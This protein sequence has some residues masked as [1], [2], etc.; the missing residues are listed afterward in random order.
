[1]AAATAPDS[2]VK[3]L[4]NWI[5]SPSSSIPELERRDARLV[6]SLAFVL[7]IS[8]SLR[9]LFESTLDIV[10]VGSFIAMIISYTLSRTTY[11]KLAAGII[12]A[13]LIIPSLSNL[14]AIPDSSNLADWVSGRAVW[15]A[16]P[17]V[18]G[19]IF[20]SWRGILVI[21]IGLFATIA[22]MPNFND[23][24]IFN[25]MIGSMA[26]IGI[27]TAL[28]VLAQ[29]HR[30]FVEEDRRAELI[31]ANKAL[32][33]ARNNLEKR[34]DER[35][36]ELNVALQAAQH[37]DQVK[38]AFLASMSHELRTP[39]NSVINFTKFVVKGVM[40]PVTERQ[41]DTL[42]KVIASGQHLLSLINDVLD[43]SKIESGSLNLF[44]EDDVNPNEI[45]QTIID[46][47]D[48]LLIDKEIEL[49][50]DIQTELPMMLADRKRITQILLNVVSNA[51]KFTEEGFVKV[52]A[53]LENNTL[54]VTVQDTGPGIA[55]EDK[56]AVF[57]SFKQTDTGLR[58]GEGTGLGMPIS[59]NLAE[60]HGGKLWFESEVGQGTTFYVE[61]PVKSDVLKAMM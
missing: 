34:V 11:R 61:L 17:M 35:T 38:S 36:A 3:Q 53:H 9:M 13:L 15:L 25:D 51:C 26:I 31:T 1:M 41:T 27:L 19:S 14:L 24:L 2:F 16:L 52:S 30:F 59:R 18:L 58:Q 44:I 32:E 22:L 54:L 39:L 21:G 12:I 48:S 37:A 10:V 8:F 20:F 55:P 6:T 45:L 46:S 60:A 49:K 29:R 7:V 33:D 57:T 50:R 43:M 42:N 4:D 23:A 40:G 28:L 47:T 56:D 5:L